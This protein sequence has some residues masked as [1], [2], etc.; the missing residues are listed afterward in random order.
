MLLRDVIFGMRVNMN[1]NLKELAGIAGIFIVF[2][3]GMGIG[4]E[5]T[6]PEA[7]Q[8]ILT[9]CFNGVDTLN[10]P[11][12]TSAI[13]DATLGRVDQCSQAIGVVLEKH[14]AHSL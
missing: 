9:A 11:S 13:I 5:S 4:V 10:K 8:K 3:I 7:G 1:K 12:H 6:S 14:D 2:N